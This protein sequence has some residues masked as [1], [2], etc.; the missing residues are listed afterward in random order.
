MKILKF[1][2]SSIADFQAIT[3]T[4]TIIKKEA[5]N[6]EIAVVFS[7]F[8]GVTEKLLTCS[9]L[10][11]RNDKNYQSILL[12]LENRHL[13]LVK[14]LISVQKQ[15]PVLTYVKIRFNELEDLL[16]GIFLIKECTAQTSD[17]VVSF[18]ERISA[19]ILSETLKDEGSIFLDARQVIRT[20][21]RFGH[22]K[23]NFQVS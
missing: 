6:E 3:H 2:G 20:N 12:E 18:G 10:A 21:N 19:Y 5:R 8:G 23:V 1:G 13:S 16:H 22:A 17:Y 4:L 9:Q 11:K 15:S 14:Q 7:A